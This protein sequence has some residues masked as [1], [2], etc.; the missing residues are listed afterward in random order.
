MAEREYSITI[1]VDSINGN[2]NNPIA[3][4]EKSPDSDLAKTA[5]F[6]NKGQA[7]AFG[8]GVT[9]YHY[10]KSFT[11]QIISH[12]VSLV[13]LRTGSRELQERAN[14]MLNVGN[15]LVGATESIVV[16]AAVGGIVGAVAGL[17]TSGIHL[18]VS[19]QQAQNTINT[20]RNVENVSLGLTYIR[21]GA[22]GS[23]RQ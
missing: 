8:K 3:G 17:V 7:K 10:A 20:Q 18:A 2:S 16:G 21:A 13:E 14:F 1:E 15:K 19:Y 23:R 4:D 9:A 12:E 11:S 22:N 5:G 6:L